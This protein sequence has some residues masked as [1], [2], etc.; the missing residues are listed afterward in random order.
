[1]LRYLNG[2][3]SIVDNGNLYTNRVASGGV[4]DGAKSGFTVT[5]SVFNG[6]SGADFALHQGDG[7][8]R[9]TSVCSSLAS[10]GAVAALSEVSSHT[11]TLS[12]NLRTDDAL[13]CASLATVWN[14]GKLR[15]ASLP[16]ESGSPQPSESASPEE[17]ESTSPEQSESR[18][19]EASESRSLVPSQSAPSG[20]SESRSPIQSESSSPSLSGCNH[21]SG[22]NRQPNRQ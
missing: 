17:S 20:P 1:M 11:V 9:K 14:R 18:S 7:C 4:I 13:M 5:R 19:L 2:R 21:R 6:N 10:T 8:H 15:T 16:S 22:R 12:A 3:E